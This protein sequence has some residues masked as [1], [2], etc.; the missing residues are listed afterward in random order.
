MGRAA[1]RAAG[2]RSTTKKL[3][4]VADL[5]ARLFGVAG[6]HDRRGGGHGGGG[7]RDEHASRHCFCKSSCCRAVGVPVWLSH[8]VG[9]Y[10]T[11]TVARASVPC[12]AQCIRTAAWVRHEIFGKMRAR[13][14]NYSLNRPCAWAGTLRGLLKNGCAHRAELFG[15]FLVFSTVEMRIRTS[16]LS[17]EDTPLTGSDLSGSRRLATARPQ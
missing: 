5:G 3:L 6:R 11:D 15:G 2:R 4:T 9:G 7:R 1:Y 10:G 13:R 17:S 14:R 8:A 12:S 16:L